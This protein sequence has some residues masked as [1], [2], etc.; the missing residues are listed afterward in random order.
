VGFSGGLDST[1]VALLCREALGS[2]NVEL[3]TV[4]YGKYTYEKSRKIVVDSAERMGLKHTFLYCGLQE[5]IWENGPSCNSCTRKVKLGTLRSYAHGRTIVTGANMT[6]SWGKTGLRMFDGIYS[7]LIDLDKNDIRKILERYDFKLVKIGESAGREGC[8]LKH[9]LKMMIN[10][11]FHGTTVARA[12]ETVL[13]MVDNCE[14][15]NVKII[16]PLSRNIAVI[17]VKPMPVNIK[18]IALEVEKIPGISDVIVASEP[19]KLVIVSSPAIYRNADA[20]HW[21]E[22]G[23]LQPEFAVPL[24]FEWHEST[25]NRLHTF[26][27]VEARCVSK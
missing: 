10:P 15:A 7:P 19:L 26:Q 11:D 21:V 16:G 1:A 25:N 13:A 24:E 14:L 2:G 4:D 17:N 12:N 8:K 5:K 22:K 6:D 18:E 27:V 20:R 3:V 9:L 23:T